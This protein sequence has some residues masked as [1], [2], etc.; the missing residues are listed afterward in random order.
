MWMS[1]SWEIYERW[2]FV[3]LG[4]ML[5]AERPEWNW[6]RKNDRWVGT[7]CGQT[8]ELLLQPT[9]PSR[10]VPHPG[11][12]SISKER[13]PDLVLQVNSDEGARFVVLDAKYRTSRTAVLDAMESAHIYQDS[14]RLGSRRPDASVLLVPAGGGASWLED[15]EFYAK[16]RVGVHVL[17]ARG[18]THLPAVIRAA[19][20][21]VV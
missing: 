2:C 4:R 8:A 20:C 3:R 6:Q 15:E 1:P 9:F 5:A 11:L 16:H 13:V 21:E 7:H 12:W 17:S 18:E 14:L 10:P 19:L